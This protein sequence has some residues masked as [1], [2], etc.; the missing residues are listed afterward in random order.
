MRMSRAGVVLHA[1]FA[2]AAIVVLI[3]LN[4][5]TAADPISPQERMELKG[6]AAMARTMAPPTTEKFDEWIVTWLEFDSPASCQ[7][8]HLAGAPPLTKFDRFATVFVKAGDRPTIQSLIND[9][10]IVWFETGS[11]IKLP[12]PKGQVSD[13]AS[14][15]DADPIVRGGLSIN[16]KKYTGR[17]VVVAIADSG[18]DFRNDD[19]ITLDAN[20]QKVSRLRYFWDTLSDAYEK[21]KMGGP[22][23]FKYPNGQSLGTLYTRDQLTAEL[24]SGTKTIPEPDTHGHGTS[25]A[26]IAAG[27]GRSLPGPAG[28]GPYGRY[29]GVAPEADLV[30]IRIGPG[31]GVPNSYLLGAI[32]DWLD[33]ECGQTPVVIN[34]SIGAQYGGHDGYLIRE[35]ELDAR[36]G[37]SAHG[38]AICLAAG[39]EA[40]DGLHLRVK[41]K[42]G[43]TATLSWVPEPAM[44]E[45]PVTRSFV[46]VYLDGG[47]PPD[48]EWQLGQ[49]VEGRKPYRNPLSG[50][51]VY[52]FVGPPKGE[53]KVK[54][55]TGAAQLDA[56]LAVD[57]GFGR[58]A[59]GKDTPT[60][61]VSVPGTSRGVITVGSYDFSDEFDYKGRAVRIPIFPYGSPRKYMDVGRLSN[62]SNPGFLRKGGANADN[63]KPDIVAPGQYHVTPAVAANKGK[64]DL[65]TSG[66]YRF[67]NGT[68]AATPYVTGVV[69]LMFEKNP[70]MSPDQVK[71]ILREHATKD[72]D[73]G[74]DRPNPGWGYGKLNLRAVQAALQAVPSAQ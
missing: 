64:L 33:K 43:E 32:C 65:D 41:P 55:K 68:S 29:A 58:F 6:A 61:L 21:N 45:N 1:L 15:G 38:R 30:A 2:S 62:S 12:P 39:N 60:E 53:I 5:T 74:D 36:F 73:V 66:K 54:S 40:E 9:N 71:R 24:R 27:N 20:G 72:S 70:R 50:S 7:K 51:I 23:P 13:V 63:C 14:R 11:H 28:S 56:Y 26:A 22:A 49:G 57:N 8:F 46:T 19:F 17:G 34:G 3:A 4:S 18:V 42:A 25:C 44:R 48:L 59:I 31:P 52:E 67:F 10:S 47:E 69:A 37:P 35:R 16:G